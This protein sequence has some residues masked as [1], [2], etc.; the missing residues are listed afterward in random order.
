MDQINEM[1]MKNALHL[2]KTTRLQIQ[3][4][5]QLCGIA[6]PNYF[7]KLFKRFYGLTPAQFRKDGV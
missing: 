2:L 3:N 1:R 6:D 5:A 7:T 4:I